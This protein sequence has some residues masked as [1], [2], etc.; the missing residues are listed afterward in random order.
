MAK[1]I[2]GTV[3]GQISGS[4][5]STVFSHNRYGSYIRR[6]SVPTNPNTTYQQN[7]RSYM[8]T[9]SSA[10]AALT[11]AQ[12]LAWKAWAAS[13]QIVDALGQK[14]TLSASAAYVQLNSRI[15]YTGGTILT[16]PP[17]VAA[18]TSLLSIT[19][20]GDIGAGDCQLAFTPTPCPAGIGVYV[21]AC[22][23]TSAGVAYVRNRL[24]LLSVSAAA[25]A[26]PIALDATL[27]ARFGTL[28]V[29]QTLHIEAGTWR[30]AD[31][32]ISVPLSSSIVLTS[33]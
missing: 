14:V 1:I 19:L 9:A 4:I 7:V 30:I 10:Y 3:A 28:F 15:L 18:P 8:A 21:K 27:A 6:R 32:Q 22:V 26:S 33:T 25:A 13:N 11:A 2:P 17:V 24:R 31:G 20:S 23:V 29:G 5:G 12:K 16:D